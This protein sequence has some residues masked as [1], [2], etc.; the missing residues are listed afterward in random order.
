MLGVLKLELQELSIWLIDNLKI[1]IS[2]LLSLIVIP[3]IKFY[4]KEPFENIL[5][6]FKFDIITLFSG[7]VISIDTIIIDNFYSKKNSVDKNITLQ[8]IF[9]ENIILSIFCLIGRVRNYI[10][11]INKVRLCKIEGDNVFRFLFSNYRKIKREGLKIGDIN[12]IGHN[13]PW[14]IHK[15][16]SLEDSYVLENEYFLSNDYRHINII[17]IERHYFFRSWFKINGVKWSL[18]GILPLL[19]YVAFLFLGFKYFQDSFLYFSIGL[20]VLPLL[21]ILIQ[22]KITFKIIKENKKMKKSILFNINNNFSL[23]NI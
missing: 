17:T 1:I 10:F 21:S 23:Y 2:P 22:A 18:M 11:L 19:L 8:L 3:I 14:E 6:I 12:F 20:S 4:G 9:I 15:E 7:L 16:D 5:E 13:T